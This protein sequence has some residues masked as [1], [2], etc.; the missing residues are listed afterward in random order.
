MPTTV[1]SVTSS[2]S[3]GTKH[4]ED[5]RDD[6]K[7][8]IATI[9]NS[10][11]KQQENTSGTPGSESGGV[12][13]PTFAMNTTPPS[14]PDADNTSI[15][16]E[17]EAV[18]ERTDEPMQDETTTTQTAAASEAAEAPQTPI[19]SKEHGAEEK[20][21]ATEEETKLQMGKVSR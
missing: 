6:Q 17:P 10:N 21:D 8:T 5:D 3:K 14:P 9:H 13:P 20:K 1:I 19:T 12:D 18:P 2:V 15:S 16:T 11:P 4:G 7:E